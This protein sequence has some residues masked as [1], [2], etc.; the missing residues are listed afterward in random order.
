MQIGPSLDY[1]STISYIPAVIRRRLF[2][3]AAVLLG[4]MAIA[5]ACAFPEPAAVP[6]EAGTPV[7][8]GVSADG[9]ARPADALAESVLHLPGNEDVDPEGGAQEASTRPD[10]SFVV[11]DAASCADPCD[12]DEDGVRSDDASCDPVGNDCNDLDPF[13]PHDGF[14][15]DKPVGHEGDWNC[16]G[17]VTKQF[18]V[19][20]SC[21]LLS[22]CKA[23]GFTTDPACG[24]TGDFVTCKNS[25]LPFVVCEEA[26]RDSRAQG[27]R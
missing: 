10:G 5:S 18:P 1:P 11:V 9:G 16:D 2:L 8:S 4:A 25:L 13:I 14:V 6:E 21:G 27:C 3:A 22:D 7:E 26:S 24:G 15:A 20:V 19:N 23:A 17:K 12:C